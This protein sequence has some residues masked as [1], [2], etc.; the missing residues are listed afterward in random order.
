MTNLQFRGIIKVGIVV[1]NLKYWIDQGKIIDV[2]LNHSVEN[3]RIFKTTMVIL[4][5]G[6][7]NQEMVDTL[8]EMP[9]DMPVV[10]VQTVGIDIE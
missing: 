9:V 4:V 8:N 10:V 6:E 1:Y 7:A 5:R 3:N 2:S